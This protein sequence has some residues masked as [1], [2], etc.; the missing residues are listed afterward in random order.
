[1]A[2]IVA[3]SVTFPEP[4]VYDVSIADIVGTE[5]RRAADGGLLADKITDKIT[6]KLGWKYLTNAQY[7]TVL[8][9]FSTFFFSVVYHDPRTGTTATKTFYVGD[10]TCGTFKYL[11]GA[12]VGWKDVGFTFIER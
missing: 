1:M 5:T 2:L 3:N 12:I 11:S 8:G 10:R 7:V 9:A 4:S 6:I